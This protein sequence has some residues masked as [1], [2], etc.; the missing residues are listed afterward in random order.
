MFLSKYF[1]K[2]ILKDF[3]AKEKNARK[4]ADVLNVGQNHY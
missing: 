1:Q 4:K 3:I 2:G